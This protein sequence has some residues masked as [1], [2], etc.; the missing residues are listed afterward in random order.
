ME[1]ILTILIVIIIISAYT[2]FALWQREKEDADYYF[3]LYKKSK[4]EQNLYY[5]KA[6]KELKNRMYI[7]QKVMSAE[8]LDRLKKEIFCYRIDNDGTIFK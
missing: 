1:I 6:K 7:Q 5:T 8:D 3:W 4:D 2:F